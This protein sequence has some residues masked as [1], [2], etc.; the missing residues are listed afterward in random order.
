MQSSR[1]TACK[2][3]LRRTRRRRQTFDGHLA[4]QAMA[5][6]VFAAHSRIVICKLQLLG[7]SLALSLACHTGVCCI[8][9]FIYYTVLAGLHSICRCQCGV[10]I[11]CVEGQKK[12]GCCSPFHKRHLMFYP[13]QRRRFILCSNFQGATRLQT[14]LISSHLIK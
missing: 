3:S 7:L 14:R 12:D 4:W 1:H 8:I 2:H 9:C 10:T 5:M 13:H 11:W 6:H